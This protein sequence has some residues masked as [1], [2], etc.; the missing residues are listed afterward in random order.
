MRL[1]GRGL[2]LMNQDRTGD[3]FVTILVNLPKKLTSKQ[4]EIVEQ[5]AAEGL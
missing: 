3:L 5:L 1:P 4:R 2:P